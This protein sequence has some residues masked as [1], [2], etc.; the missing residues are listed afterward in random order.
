[1]RLWLIPALCAAALAAPAQADTT[2][3]YHAGNWDAFEATGP[4]G[5]PVCGIGSHNIND[6]SILSL[7]YQL[8]TGDVVFIVSK[9]GW[10]IPAGTRLP[11]VMQVGL[12]PPWTEQATGSGDSA[13][14]TIDGN[15]MQTFDAQFRG[16]SSMTLTFPSGTEPPWVLGLS[17]SAAIDNAMGRCI[18]DLR[19]R[20][21]APAAAAPQSTTQPFA[22]PAAPARPGG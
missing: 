12:S 18:N 3:Y 20:P 19:Q 17:G 9:P 16:A 11:V 10:Q 7:R 8:G 22:Q 15:A 21:A 1:M 2:I 14:W 13:Q 4:D 5:Q 6:G